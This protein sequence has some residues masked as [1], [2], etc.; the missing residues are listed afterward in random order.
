MILLAYLLTEPTENEVYPGREEIASHCSKPFPSVVHPIGKRLEE[1]NFER[2]SFPVKV[3]LSLY[4]IKYWF[5]RI[6][7]ADGLSAS[8]LQRVT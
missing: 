7:M 2:V 8:I 6:K 5:E 4:K 1:N 3:S